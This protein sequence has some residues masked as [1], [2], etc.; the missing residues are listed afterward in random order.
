MDSS[1]LLFIDDYS[2]MTWV[3]FTKKKYEAFETFKLLNKAIE[4]KTKLKVKYLRSENGG[5]F[6]S[7]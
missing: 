7:K 4:N 1:I 6:T 3:S 2:M 5:E